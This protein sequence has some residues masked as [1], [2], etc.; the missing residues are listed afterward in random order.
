M[1]VEAILV[2]ARLLGEYKICSYSDFGGFS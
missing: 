1:F 2:I